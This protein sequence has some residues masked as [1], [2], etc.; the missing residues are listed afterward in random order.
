MC[1]GYKSQGEE[2]PKCGE[3][4]IWRFVYEGEFVIIS[5]NIENTF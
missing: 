1:N 5:S 2:D 3:E 4:M